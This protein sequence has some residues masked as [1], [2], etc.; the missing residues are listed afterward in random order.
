VLC[1]G[2]LWVAVQGAAG[3]DQLRLQRRAIMSEV[4]VPE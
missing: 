2:Q 3:F 4:V 1:E